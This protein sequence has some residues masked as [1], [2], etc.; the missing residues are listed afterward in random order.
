M[1]RVL[2]HICKELDRNQRD[3]RILKRAVRKYAT[4]TMLA[5]V[6]VC[7]LGIDVYNNT[8]KIEKLEAEIKELKGE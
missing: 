5:G 4:S 8:K 7:M 1:V 3:I 2:E 6:C